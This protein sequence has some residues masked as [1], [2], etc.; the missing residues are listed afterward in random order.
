MD[1]LTLAGIPL[2]TPPKP[3]PKAK[4]LGSRPPLP[5][6]DGA[7]YDHARDGV[8]LT[9]QLRR[10]LDAMKDGQWHTLHQ[11]HTT[12]GDPEASISARLRDLRKPRHGGLTILRRHKANGLHEYR[13]QVDGHSPGCNGT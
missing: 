2:P 7:T 3:P 13:L 10:V 4:G 1:Q 8:R 6:F 9:H 11:L 5:R 12:T